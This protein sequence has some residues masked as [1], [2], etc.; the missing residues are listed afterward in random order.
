MN[1]R[2]YW[3]LGRQARLVRWQSLAQDLSKR[4]IRISI[5]WR[6]TTLGAM[7]KILSSILPGVIGLILLSRAEIVVQ[8]QIFDWVKS[9]SESF[10][11]TCNACGLLTL[12]HALYENS[13]PCAILL[14]NH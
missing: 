7:R 6:M 12:D 14:P 11:A 1:A 5:L 4:P 3:N 2:N 9:N 13:P 8:M 10:N